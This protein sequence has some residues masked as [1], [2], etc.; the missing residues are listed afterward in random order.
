MMAR[1]RHRPGKWEKVGQVALDELE[2]RQRSWVPVRLA[3]HLEEEGR[4]VVLAPKF[5]N[6]FGRGLVSLMGKDQE[7]NL[8]LDEFGSTVWE[9]IDGRRS[10]GEIA[11]DLAE[12]FGKE[13]EPAL[14]RLL[15]FMRSLH[16]AGVIE[17]TTFENPEVGFK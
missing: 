7:Y 11:D 13:V 1:R 9:L 15:M 16:N 6:R 2:T 8:R 5:R 14:P 17:V 12:R 3:E 4:M 10:L